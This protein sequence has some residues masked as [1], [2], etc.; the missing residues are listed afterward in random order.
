M[1]ETT[2]L[3]L[4]TYD[5]NADGDIGF[6]ELRKQINGISDSNMTKFDS[7]AGQLV[8]DIPN[9]IANYSG[10]DLSISGSVTSAS[11]QVEASGSQ[12]TDVISRFEVIDTFSS[13]GYVDFSSI[14]QDYTH[15]LIM[16]T[17][18]TEY[19]DFISNVGIDFNGDAV[20]SHYYN[21]QWKRS[22][23]SSSSETVETFTTGGSCVLV[24]NVSGYV[25]GC[26]TEL[27][28]GSMYVLVPHYSGSTSF[29]KT[30]MGFSSL[31]QDVWRDTSLSSGAWLATNP[32]NRIR[33]FGI[34][35]S[36]SKYGFMD[37]TE[38]TLYGIE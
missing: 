24:G 19:P 10:S 30:S 6:D 8:L 17:A 35:T 13:A 29:Y 11:A 7:F 15:L 33:I 16:G 31:S 22:G 26:G 18:A 34:N 21:N 4:F 1:G 28:G 36:G 2:N 37:G 3:S 5:L 23:S 14:P 27:F 25:S 38:I 32:I 20:A 9:L 12:I